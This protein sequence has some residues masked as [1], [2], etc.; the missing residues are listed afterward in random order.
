MKWWPELSTWGAADY[1]VKPFSPTELVARARAALRR[2]AGPSRSLITEPYVLGDLT[3]DYTERLVTLAGRPVQ[4]TATEY[5]L[6]LELSVDAGQV[7]THDQL[8]RRVWGPKK[9]G[10]LRAL[11]AH[12][13]R[14]R[15]KPGRGRERPNLLVLG[16]ESRLSHA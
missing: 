10:D 6:L 12:V 9:L 3:I 14:I 5:Q 2:T 15:V 8:L 7:L 1:I 11:R 13:R 4:M 16:S